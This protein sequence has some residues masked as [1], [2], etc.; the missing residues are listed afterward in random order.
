MI[1]LILCTVKHHPWK[2][3]K[4]RG[5]NFGD[6]G[7]INY[8]DCRDDIRSMHF[9]NLSDCIHYICTYFGYQLLP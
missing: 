8:L 5:I 9:T 1:D 2:Q 3:K 7:C 4:Q 6:G